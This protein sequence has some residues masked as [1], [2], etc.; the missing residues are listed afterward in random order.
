MPG[1]PKPGSMFKAAPILIQVKNWCEKIWLS[2][3]GFKEV[4]LTDDMRK[5]WISR[6]QRLLTLLQLHG[7]SW[8]RRRHK[9]GKGAVNGIYNLALFYICLIDFLFA[10]I[11]TT[12]PPLLPLKKLRVMYRL[13]RQLTS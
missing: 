2:M 1:L 8:R 3:T 12:P 7:Y 10:H 5:R 6:L 11:V 4:T 13:L 9:R